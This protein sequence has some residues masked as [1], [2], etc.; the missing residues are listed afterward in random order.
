MG[1]RVRT[2]RAIKLKARRCPKCNR[3][4]DRQ[5]TRCPTCH[6]TQPALPKGRG[7]VKP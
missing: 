1:L 4:L 5:R 3:K 2:K 7:K 6:K